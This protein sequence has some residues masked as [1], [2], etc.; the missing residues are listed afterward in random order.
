M[1]LRLASA[2]RLAE[3]CSEFICHECRRDVILPFCERV[4]RY[5]R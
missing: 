3:G 5:E 2:R 1:A 4:L